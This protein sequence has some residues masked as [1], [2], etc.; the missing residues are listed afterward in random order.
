MD[1]S[2]KI[3][4]VS[5]VYLAEKIVDQ[6]VKQIAREVSKLT[7]DFEIILVED[8]SPDNSWEKIVENCQKYDFVK[9]V[10][11]SRNFGQHPA[12][13]AGLDLAEGDYVVV[14][15]CDLQDDPKY[16]AQLLNKSQEGFDIVFTHKEG[17]KHSFFKNATATIFNYIFN[18]L[19][20]NK[21]F[22]GSNNVGSY[23]LLTRKVVLAFRRFNDYQRHYLM[24][25]R[26]L[27]Y[28]HAFIKIK[29]LERFEGKS[30]Y[31]LKTLVE[32]AIQGI[33]S[34]SDKLLRLNIYVGFI[35]AF[36]AFI[37]GVII[38]SLYFTSGLMNGWTSLIVTLFFALG[39]ILIS[40]GIVGIYIGKIFEQVKDRPKYLIDNKLNF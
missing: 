18:Y 13:T 23:S 27:G 12:V 8:G 36:I 17:R 37:A 28:S 11:L 2:F 10:K 9:G 40:I 5:P 21:R 34:Q 14:M 4:I 26:W 32:H 19:I 25:L 31:N 1:N 35:I 15:D 39:I 29:H 6:L 16:I 30:S 33:T 3:S 7:T 38:I 24:V 20:D 22:K